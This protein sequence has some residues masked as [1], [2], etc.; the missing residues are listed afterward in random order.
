MSLALVASGTVLARQSPAP[1]QSPAWLSA[2]GNPHVSAQTLAKFKRAFLSVRKIEK[3]YSTKVQ[4]THSDKVAVKLREWAQTEMVTA[5]K[6]A[7]LTVAQFDK[8]MML[9]RRDPTLRKQLL[10]Q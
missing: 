3:E 2:A 7:G 8:M 10:G 9:V 4:Q 5:V 6:S 1:E